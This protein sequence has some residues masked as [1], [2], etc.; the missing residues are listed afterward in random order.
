VQHHIWENGQS[1]QGED[2]QYFGF[3]YMDGIHFFLLLYPGAHKGAFIIATL[4]SQRKHERDAI[5]MFRIPLF[6]KQNTG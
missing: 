3:G 4:N 1:P 2:R 6:D 5:I